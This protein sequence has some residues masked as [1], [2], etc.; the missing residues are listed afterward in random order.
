MPSR[1]AAFDPTRRQVIRSLVGGS[2]LMPA[3]LQQ[4]LAESGD[5][6]APKAPHFPGKAK[7]VIFLYCSGGTSHM[8]TFDPKPKLTAAARD[9][10]KA[11]NGKPYLGAFWEFKQESKCGTEVS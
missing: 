9:G 4:C 7:R 8:D 2:A 10:K 6:L 3:I 11:P 5:D 1:F